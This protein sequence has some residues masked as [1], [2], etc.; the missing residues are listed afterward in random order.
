MAK[1]VST[2]KVGEEAPGILGGQTRN[3]ICSVRLSVSVQQSGVCLYG[4]SIGATSF[5]FRCHTS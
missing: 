3:S 2:P 1:G 5:R 4:K